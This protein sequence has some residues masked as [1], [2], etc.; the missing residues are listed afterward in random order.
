MWAGRARL[1]L[2]RPHPGVAPAEGGRPGSQRG[3]ERLL[4]GGQGRCRIVAEPFGVRLLADG[5][6]DG[7]R[8]CRRVDRGRLVG[9]EGDVG[10]RG[11]Q[12]LEDGRSGRD[13]VGRSHAADVAGAEDALPADA[14]TAELVGHGVGTGA[15][16]HELGIGRQRQEVA[17]VTQ[18]RDRL[19]G[20]LQGGVP[21]RGDRGVGLARV[22]VRVVEEPQLKLEPQDP[23]YGLVD[24]FDGDQ[25]LLYVLRQPGVP[26]GVVERCHRHVD[27]GVDGFGDGA[28][29]IG[30]D[31]VVV[32]KRRNVAE[33]ADDHALEAEALAQ[34]GGEQETRCRSRNVVDRS[35]VDHDSRGVRVDGAG[36]GGQE[37]VLQVPDR[38]LR[39]DPVVP[40][41]RL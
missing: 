17:L 6:H 31:V 27:A 22:H 18:Q 11:L 3:D 15:G 26:A 36:I 5:H 34:L 8:G 20:R 29:E 30:G 28:G 41:D 7:V 21:A 24:P 12:S 23:A 25:A 10:I 14:P 35:G 33:V 13:L 2:G 39:L 40:V 1:P 38:Q 37:H 19:L 4:V 32:G 9:S 16:D